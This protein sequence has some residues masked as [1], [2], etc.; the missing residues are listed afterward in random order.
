VFLPEVWFTAAYATRH[1]KCQVPTALTLAMLQAMAYAGLLPF[2]YVVADCLYGHS[3]DLLDAVDAGIGVTT[4]V[5][6]PADSRG[7]LQAPRTEA[8]VYRYQ[9][10]VRSKRVGEPDTAPCTVAAVAARLPPSRG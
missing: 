10:A 5:A 2:K 4:V 8:H 7:W 1:T 9:G 3:P 6:S